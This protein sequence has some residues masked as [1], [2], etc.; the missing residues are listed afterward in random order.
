MIYP[1]EHYLNYDSQNLNPE[2]VNSAPLFPDQ[3]G[4]FLKI[5]SD[6]KG[7]FFVD[8]ETNLWARIKRFVLRLLNYRNYHIDQ[9]TRLERPKGHLEAPT[10]NGKLI[11][12]LQT[13][14]AK[15]AG[16]SCYHRNLKHLFEKA[17]FPHL[18]GGHTL[19]D[20]QIAFEQSLSVHW[21]SAE[22]EFEQIRKD[23]EIFCTSGNPFLFLNQECRIS[24]ISSENA[25]HF[26]SFSSHTLK[27]KYHDMHFADY[28]VQKIACYM[29]A[30][31]GNDEFCY[32]YDPHN[33]PENES[34][35]LGPEVGKNMVDELIQRLNRYAQGIKRSHSDWLEHLSAAD[36]RSVGL[37]L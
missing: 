26:P 30:F 17:V 34:L 2:V 5:Y 24:T 11:E 32:D 23:L 12:H 35:R 16:N 15:N 36:S 21:S 29:L 31:T 1:L 4:R 3:P 14:S 9:M 19:S 7:I 33:Q 25:Q 13:L 27:E 6:K 10:F 8:C 18:N 37:Y 22:K 20:L 28:K